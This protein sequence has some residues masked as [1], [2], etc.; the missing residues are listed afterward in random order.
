MLS[1][2]QSIARMQQIAAPG[3]KMGL[4]RTK[5]L[6]SALGDPQEKLRVIHVAGTNGKGSFSAMLS[7]VL[8]A[9]GFKT[10]SFNSPAML[11][12]SD[13]FG[14]NCKSVPEPALAEAINAVCDAAEALSDTPTEFEMITAAAFRLFFRE[15]CDICVMECGMGGDTDSTNV[16]SSPL[17]SVIT[18]VAVDHAAFLG[19]TTAEIASHKAGI[20]KQGRPVYF[21]GNDPQALKV[22]S[23]RAD[24]LSAKLYLPE[25]E[26]VRF[27]DSNSCTEFVYKHRKLSCPLRGVYQQD[28]IINVLSCID[29][30]RSLGIKITSEAVKQ[31]LS[32]VRWPG[33][34]ETLS[35]EPKMIFDG[36][37][38][39]D[40][41]QSL[42]ES[43]KLYYPDR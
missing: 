36:A 8:T 42:C 28:N 14:I 25:R 4:E 34:F 35:S 37:H 24:A 18:N 39:P 6:L 26:S 43:I 38:N 19:S 41:M 23:E 3:M 11:E 32:E 27:L 5:A 16:I 15:S 10:G 12:L 1:A 31:G 40:G 29:I 17:L 13:Q 2:A 30:L 21:G 20:I 22:I 7:S 9:Q 33:R